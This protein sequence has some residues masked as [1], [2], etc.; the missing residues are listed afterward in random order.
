MSEWIS[1]DERLP[2]ENVD[3]LVYADEYLPKIAYCQRE[4]EFLEHA[5]AM[6]QIPT[7]EIYYWTD[8]NDDN[9]RVYPTHWQPLPE[10]PK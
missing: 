4:D 10:P 6:G 3:V 7:P 1:V 2:E 5:A 8:S 9:E